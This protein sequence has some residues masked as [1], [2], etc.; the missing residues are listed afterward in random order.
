MLIGVLTR[1]R[2]NIQRGSLKSLMKRPFIEVWVN[3]RKSTIDKDHNNMH[4]WGTI[5]QGDKGNK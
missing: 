1:N 2:Q 4:Y 3:L 5:T